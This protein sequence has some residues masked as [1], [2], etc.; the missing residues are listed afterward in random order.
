MERTACLQDLFHISLKFLI[1]IFLNKTFFPSLKCPRKGAFLHV[2]QKRCTYGN[3]RPFLDPYLSYPSVSAV[4]EPTLHVS[5]IELPRRGCSIPRPLFHST[6][7]VPRYTSPLP[8]SR[9][10]RLLGRQYSAISQNSSVFSQP[11]ISTLKTVTARRSLTKTYLP[12]SAKVTTFVGP[13][14]GVKSETHL[15]TMPASMSC[16]MIT[17]MRGTSGD[18]LRTT[19]A[20]L[21]PIMHPSDI[22]WNF[23]P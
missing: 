7:E 15:L 5:P 4:K 14:L 6:S 13:H 1:K 10:R 17:L 16:W 8:G 11:H 12:V 23:Q 20:V 22:T 19:R 21:W 3:R 9:A 18:P 2:P